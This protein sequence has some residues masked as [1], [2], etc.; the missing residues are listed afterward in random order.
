[1]TT[2]AT[3]KET[4]LGM[5]PVLSPR[6]PRT[7]WL[8]LVSCYACGEHPLHLILA[9]PGLKEETCNHQVSPPHAWHDKDSGLT[10]T[11]ILTLIMTLP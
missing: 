4:M 1:M 9:T 8:C 6:I 5:S 11:L 10:L 2:Q 3:M 7:P